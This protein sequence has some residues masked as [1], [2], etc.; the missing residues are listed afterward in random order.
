MRRTWTLIPFFMFSLL[1]GR[2]ATAQIQSTPPQSNSA[3]VAFAQM[4]A[5]TG[6]NP[7][8][9]PSDAVA[10]GTITRYHG[11]MQDTVTYTLKVKGFDEMRVELQGAAT[12][13]TIVN[14]YQAAA[15]TS[16]GTIAI[17]SHSAFSMRAMELPF[18]TSLM[19][20]AD[21]TVSIQ[22][23]GTESVNGQSTQRIEIAPQ[24][25]PGDPLSPLRCRA[26]RMTVW[27]S[28]ATGLP[29][30]IAYARIAVNNPTVVA[31]HIR[32]FSDWRVVNGMAVPFH[33]EDFLG[34]QHL[35]SLQFNSVNFN[36]ALSDSDFALPTSLQ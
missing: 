20:S 35:Y 29:V 36:V 10:T 15:T 4:L 1:L 18:F 13:T 2:G 7:Q 8:R 23:A 17:P 30:Q 25:V 34:S 33:Q 31:A 3:L 16:N 32:Q 12:S 26:R 14:G 21:P 27:I 9:L 24:S 28:T 11:D 6:W 5:A 22:S 19:N